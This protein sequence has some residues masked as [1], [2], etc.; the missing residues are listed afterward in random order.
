M[1]LQAIGLRGHWCSS[2]FFVAFVAPVALPCGYPS[3]LTIWRVSFGHQKTRSDFVYDK[4]RLKLVSNRHCEMILGSS[5]L[6]NKCADIVV[7]VAW[8]EP[9]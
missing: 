5:N 7:L 6:I 8:L 4:N 9:Q 3:V 2:G 1:F